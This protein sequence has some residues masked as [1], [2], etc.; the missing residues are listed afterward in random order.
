MKTIIRYNIVFTL[1][2]A[3]HIFRKSFLLIK[4]ILITKLGNRMGVI[5]V[6]E[7]V[8]NFMYDDSLTILK[9]V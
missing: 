8:E 1:T 9:D 7:M 5:T 6:K 3:S 4:K 2:P